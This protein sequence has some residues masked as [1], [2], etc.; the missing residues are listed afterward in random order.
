MASGQVHLFRKLKRRIYSFFCFAGANKQFTDY[1]RLQNYIR[2]ALNTFQEQFKERILNSFITL[3]YLVFSFDARSYSHCANHSRQCTARV[4][5]VSVAND[6]F[7]FGFSNAFKYTGL[8][9]PSVSG[10]LGTQPNINCKP[11]K[12]K[13]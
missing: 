8:F 6:E 10:I 2:S 11:N 7:L 12:Y 3:L 9:R 5:R 4:I 13:H 1:L